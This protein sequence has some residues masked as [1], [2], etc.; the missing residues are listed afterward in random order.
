MFFR[1]THHDTNLL[2]ILGE[3]RRQVRSLSH[4]AQLKQF[5]TINK[6]FLIIMTVLILSPK[7]LLIFVMLKLS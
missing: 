4:I 5:K 3:G 6:H 7:I 1:A 2:I